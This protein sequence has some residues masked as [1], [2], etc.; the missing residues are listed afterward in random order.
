M[1]SRYFAVKYIEDENLPMPFA[2]DQR[3]CRDVFCEDNPGAYK[4]DSGEFEKRAR[5]F[6]GYTLALIGCARR[7]IRL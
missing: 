6:G 4:A 1:T 5:E 2:F 3:I 7:F